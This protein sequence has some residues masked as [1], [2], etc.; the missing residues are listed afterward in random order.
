MT[1][2]PFIALKMPF[3]I[4][5]LIRQQLGERR[6]AGFLRLGQ[7]HLAHRLDP[8]ALEEHVLGAAQ[9]DPFGAEIAG[10]LGVGRRIGIRANLERAILVGPFHHGGEIAGELWLLRGDRSP[11]ITSPVEP[12]IES[13]SLC[14]KTLPPTVIL[15]AF[16][17]I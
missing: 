14:V 6:H 9:A 7:N 8:L 10:P 3:E 13:T 5:A 12:S 17:S 15:R 1:G 2:K 4:L 16:S 11:T